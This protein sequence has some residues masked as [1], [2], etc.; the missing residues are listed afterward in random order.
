MPKYDAVI[1]GAGVAGCAVAALLAKA[2]KRV[3]ITDPA[4]EP[5]GSSASVELQGIRFSG[6]PMCTY[7]FEE[8]GA[9]HSMLR[10]IGLPQS[11]GGP[12]TSYQVALP[13]RRI[14]VS[15][16]PGAT[17]EEL[18]RE[19][20]SEIDALSRF[21][22]DMAAL[23]GRMTRSRVWSFVARRRRA[24]DVL[25]SYGFS[26]ELQAFFS[27]ASFV[28]FGRTVQDLALSELVRL[29]VTAP[30]VITDG[31]DRIAEEL[32]G[33]VVRHG[34]ECRL[35]EPWPELLV[36]RSRLEGI[37]SVQGRIELRSAVL[38]VPWHVQ[39]AALFS[40]VREEVLPVGMLDTVIVANEYDRPEEAFL[41]S[42]EPQTSAGPSDGRIRPLKAFFSHL[43][44]PGA[45]TEG[46]IRKISDIIPFLADFTQASALRAGE[47]R[48]MSVPGSGDL[49]K[50]K[51]GT[52]KRNVPV[53]LPVRAAT[54]I[55]DS[56]FG[57]AQAAQGA[58]V[59]AARLL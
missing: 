42:V 41:L 56:P 59:L 19:Y 4:K 34:G 33:F 21:Y 17:L 6:W 40:V 46:L 52:A 57:A 38:N 11:A 5:G 39:E 18:R 9:W 45:A 1:L 15:P 48:T 25:R 20:P 14:T 3:L 16:D 51:P 26:R 54:L 28:F 53:R 22:R 10:E 27:A 44:H 49:L 50:G 58:R 29:A 23:N 31:F 24:G 47:D 35:G 30:R 13:G 55:T 12:G 32:R 8:G 7:G 37:Q 43:P 36:R 2:G